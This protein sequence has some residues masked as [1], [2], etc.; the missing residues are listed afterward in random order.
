MIVNLMK[1][2]LSI[3]VLLFTEEYFYKLL[4]LLKLSIN[5]QNIVSL[6][7]YILIFIIIFIIYKPEIKAAFHK[8]KH[9]LTTNIFYS[10]ASFIIVF[11]GMMIIDYL[12]VALSKGLN[13]TYEGLHFINIFE[14]TFSF[15]L[16]VV[17]L[18]D[19]IIKPFVKVCIFV[20]GVNNLIGRKFGTFFS[21]LLYSLF[22]VYILCGFNANISYILLN[23]IPYFCLSSMLS[24]IYIKNNNIVYSIVSFSLIELFASILIKK[25][26]WGLY[27][28]KY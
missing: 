6:I 26:V 15:E 12:L 10:I 9:K 21:G 17:I 3:L 27:E 19:I 5:S 18:K 28:K 7:V 23:M 24:Y 13:I 11:I 14:Y 25:F 22:A 20:L 8:Y 16:I 4:D 2:I 1:L